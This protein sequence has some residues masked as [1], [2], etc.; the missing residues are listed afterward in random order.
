MFLGWEVTNFDEIPQFWL[1][2]FFA[3]RGGKILQQTL[4]WS[5]TKKGELNVYYVYIVTNH[6]GRKLKI[7][8]HFFVKVLQIL[9]LTYILAKC[10]IPPTCLT[11]W[12]TF[13]QAKHHSRLNFKK[14][15][16]HMAAYLSKA[17]REKGR[18]IYIYI[19]IFVKM[20]LWYTFAGHFDI[21]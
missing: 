3:V 4:G 16:G 17:I 2:A 9:K 5:A 11:G 8:H 12:W 14:D 15:C 20:N 1:A 7:N 10:F 6:K 21:R 18:Y 19:N 13:G